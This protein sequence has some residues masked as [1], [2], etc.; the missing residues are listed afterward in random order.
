MQLIL[1][2][3][4]C[5][6]PLLLAVV[7][8]CDKPADTARVHVAVATNFVAPLE[9][10]VRAFEVR[11]AAQ[12]TVSPGST[13]KLYAQVL[14]GAPYDVLLAADSER[15]RRLLDEGQAVAGS[16]QTYAVG[17]L[18]LWRR[19]V[20]LDG[21]DCDLATLEVARLALANPALAPYGAAAREALVN[22]GAWERLAERVVYGENV[23][24][25]FAL[26]ATGNA[27]AGLVATSLLVALPSE[28]AGS[29]CAVA[30][31]L[32]EPIRQDAVLLMRAADN[33][34]AR[35]FLE[36]LQGEQA[37]GVIRRHGYGTAP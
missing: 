26:V 14:H 34:A 27:D 18:S 33:R 28:R 13:G 23:G 5:L 10:I 36:F 21:G 3:C 25:A 22:A 37:R 30:G 1:R 6:L 32:H 16:G 11:H 4:R 2:P 31:R 9:D 35:D 15:P 29:A 19:D 17:R 7:A 8:G 24:Q 20:A 12:V